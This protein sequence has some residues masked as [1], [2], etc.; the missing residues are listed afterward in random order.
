MRTPLAL[1]TWFHR[2]ALALGFAGLPEQFRR[3]LTFD[4]QQQAD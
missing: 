4:Q 3:L 2:G 1:F